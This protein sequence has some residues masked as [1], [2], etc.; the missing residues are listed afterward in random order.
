MGAVCRTSPA[1]ARV[2]EP[3][4]ET[5]RARC[6]ADLFTKRDLRDVSRGVSR[7]SR[8]PKFPRSLRVCG[9]RRPRAQTP[10]D[11]I[12]MST[13]WASGLWGYDLRRD[14][15]GRSIARG[16]REGESRAARPRSAE[17]RGPVAPRHPRRGSTRVW[18]ASSPNRSSPTDAAGGNQRRTDAPP[19]RHG[20]ARL[21][22]DALGALSPGDGCNRAGL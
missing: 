2:T 13:R 1:I 11:A 5:A 18:N 6:R 4:C 15:A 21:R 19:T 22:A 10:R 9:G 20:L 8:P 3:V 7:G 14:V 17:W 16:R 12:A